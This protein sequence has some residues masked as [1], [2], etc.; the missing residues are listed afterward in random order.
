MC[1]N[2]IHAMHQ[3]AFLMYLDRT[4]KTN[5]PVLFVSGASKRQISEPN[6]IEKVSPMGVIKAYLRTSLTTFLI[7]PPTF[8][9]CFLPT[10]RYQGGLHLSCRKS[11]ALIEKKSYTAILLR[12]CSCECRVTYASFR[13]RKANQRNISK[14]H[15][16][17]EHV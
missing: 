5:I 13:T 8:V 7:S 2:C 9:L 6:T 11:P 3:S 12:R 10:L 15:R 4:A 1:I 17:S 14:H 16:A